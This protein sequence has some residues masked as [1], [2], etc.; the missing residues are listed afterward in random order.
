MRWGGK[1]LGRVV[2]ILN[3]YNKDSLT[4]KSVFISIVGQPNVGKS[5]LLNM[6]LN[7]KISIVAPK[8]QTTRIRVNG[9]L[10]DENVQMVFNDLPGFLSPKNML[11]NYMKREI[12]NGI[13]GSDAFLYLVEANKNLSEFE[14][15]VIFKLKKLKLKKIIA[16]NKIDLIKDKSVLL[17]QIKYLSEIF[18]NNNIDI[19]LLSAKTG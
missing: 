17:K 13:L 1:T 6:V 3:A 14:K 12:E 5:S 16:I 2:F 18:D 11:N 15:K 9:V 4:T 7:R 8:P 19:L 10:T